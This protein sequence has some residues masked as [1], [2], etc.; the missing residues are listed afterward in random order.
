MK[1]KIKKIFNN[2]NIEKNK[3]DKIL[4][5]NEK[6]NDEEKKSQY[7]ICKSN[8]KHKRRGANVTY[9]NEDYKRVKTNLNKYFNNFFRNTNNL[10]K[11]YYFLMFCMLLLGVL[12]VTITFKSYNLFA[13]E[14]YELYAKNESYD[15]DT[16]STMSSVEDTNNDNNISEYASIES[17]TNILEA[18]LSE[19]KNT[20]Q[21]NSNIKTSTK[22][23]TNPVVKELVFVKPIDG[24]IQKPYSPDKVVYSKTLELW[25]TH[26]GI[27]IAS[28]IGKSVKSIEKGSVEKVYEDSFYG[29]TIVIDHG[30][31]YKSC[32]S[33]LDK[34]V[35]IKEK[36]VVNKGQVIGKIG[37]TSIGEIK[38]ESHLHFTL[39]KNN[40][41]IDPT[42]IFK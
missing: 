38:D 21:K 42:Y 35:S 13:K 41:N 33:N 34:N 26:D 11:S 5:I 16:I 24:N 39:F 27:D 29:I 7:N 15:K 19:S 2:T 4:V 40:Q 25:K 32:Y 36:Q 23:Q 28:D 31:G 17:T 37:N 6:N 18:K 9:K 20:N 30:Q 22:T 10:P 3:K 12:S 14:D 8:F 1:V